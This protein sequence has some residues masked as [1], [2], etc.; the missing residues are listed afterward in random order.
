MSDVIKIGTEYW[1]AER[2]KKLEARL[3]KAEN[4]RD[5]AQNKLYHE[6][7]TNSRNRDLVMKC[8][9]LRNAFAA[10]MEEDYERQW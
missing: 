3:S 8:E 2:I 1:D 7:L 9:A 10:L 4:D 6:K 5:E